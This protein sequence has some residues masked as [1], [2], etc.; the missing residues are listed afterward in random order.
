M[1]RPILQ[2]RHL[3]PLA[4]G[5][6]RD[7]FVHPHDPDLLVKTMKEGN[8]ERKKGSKTASPFRRY[9]Q[10]ITF[11]R[12]CEEHIAA[13]FDPH[14][15]PAFLQAVV[16][17]ADTDRGLGLVTK[18]ERDASG[19]YAKTLQ[20][21]ISQNAYDPTAQEALEDFIKQFAAS[22]VIV[23]DLSIRNLVYS[24]T[25]S[26]QPH[27]VLIDGYGEKNLIPFNSFSAWCHQ[28]S[29]DKRIKR[30]RLAIARAHAA[31]EQE[32]KATPHGH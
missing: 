5:N 9:R 3:T 2:L 13:Q 25:D 10:Y 14:G 24:I 18:A 21:L 8:E 4:S 11:L 32:Q 23:T 7:V 6:N 30:L 16:G 15:A 20:Q 26:E 27:F 19:A 22:R 17:F 12:E 29:K 1:P 31:H 28:R